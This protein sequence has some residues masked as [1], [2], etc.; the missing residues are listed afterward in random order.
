MR[1]HQQP[2]SIKYTFMQQQIT[3]C[4]MKAFCK[5]LAVGRS[6]YRSQFCRP[7]KQSKL[8]FKEAINTFYL[9]DKARA[10][11]LNIVVVIKRNKPSAA[12]VF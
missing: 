9:A 6:G 7:V 5:A 4:R 2:K 10:D 11:A 12:N 1:A 8:A 3:P